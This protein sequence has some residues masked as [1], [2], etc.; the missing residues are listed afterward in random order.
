MLPLVTQ[1]Y[2][3]KAKEWEHEQEYR[4]IFPEQ[5]LNEMNIKKKMCD[6]GKERYMYKVKITKVFLGAAMS[7]NQK[8]ELRK[9]IPPEIEIVEMKIS[10]DK[11][12]LLH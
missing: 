9:I 6:D 10:N 11:Y 5:I 8:S 1:P 2:I 4:L 7:D 12:E 3:A